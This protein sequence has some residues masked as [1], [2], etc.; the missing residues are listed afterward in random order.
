L[1]LKTV[2]DET[3]DANDHLKF[4][5]YSIM[6]PSNPFL[7]CNTTEILLN[8]YALNRKR[9]C[10]CPENTVKSYREEDDAMDEIMRKHRDD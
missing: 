4:W 3:W 9:G 5:I 8:H 10:I 6:N 1:I 2:Y 7:Q